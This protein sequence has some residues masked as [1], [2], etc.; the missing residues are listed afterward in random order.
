MKRIT[1]LFICL[2]MLATLFACSNEPKNKPL[3]MDETYTIKDELSLKWKALHFT[4]E[5]LPV[6][7]NDEYVYRYSEDEKKTLIDVQF[8]IEN[9]TDKE[10]KVDDLLKA[11]II[12]SE[13]VTYT[14]ELCIETNHL[15]E[16]YET[17]TLDPKQKSIAHLIFYVSDDTAK[18]YQSNKD[19]IAE[20]NITLDED[21]YTLPIKEETPFIKKFKLNE[22]RTFD[23]MNITVLSASASKLIV[24]INPTDNSNW[25]D[26]DEE[27][28][29]YAGMYVEIENKTD[30]PINLKQEIGAFLSIEDTEPFPSWFTILSEDNTMFIDDA[31]E[32]PAKTKRTVLFF[33]QIDLDYEDTE[34]TFYLNIDGA[35]Y[36][37]SYTHTVVAR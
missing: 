19:E 35:P 31:E 13:D 8:Y 18:S 2:N 11:Q 37:Y 17:T 29:Q 10:V 24:P 14:A 22:T 5:V 32:I 3:S 15:T 21:I 1:K 34:Y 20:M 4:K 23:S 30:K 12:E 7:I 9:L 33:Q 27:N 26:T 36:K 16:V 25:Y 28:K 6:N